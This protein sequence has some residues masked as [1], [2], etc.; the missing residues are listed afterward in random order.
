VSLF[1]S[2]P[3]PPPLTSSGL[4]FVCFYRNWS[5][6]PPQRTNNANARTPL[7]FIHPFLG[8]RWIRIRIPR[9]RGGRLLWW[10]CQSK[11]ELSFWSSSYSDEAEETLL[12]YCDCLLLSSSSSSSFWTRTFQW[13][14]NYEQK[15]NN[16]RKW[17]KMGDGRHNRRK[18]FLPKSPNLEIWEESLW[19]SFN[20][21]Q[22]ERLAWKRRVECY[23]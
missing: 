13:W 10:G 1:D 23:F 3:P 18:N 20:F 4:N 17:N 22:F 9:S 11:S 2:S 8:G 19:F 14:I 6:E 15:N 7:S 21:V 12:K 5:F 16:N